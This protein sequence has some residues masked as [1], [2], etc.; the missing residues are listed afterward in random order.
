MDKTKQYLYGFDIGTQGSKGILTDETGEVLAYHYMKH[1]VY[2]PKPGWSE[3]DPE[4][5]WWHEFKMITRALLDKSG[6][7][8]KQIL[9]VGCSAI[10]PCMLPVDKEGRPLRNAILY[11]IDTRTT[12]EIRDMNEMIGVEKIISVGK[13]QLSSQAVGPK[14]LWFRR[15]ENELFQKTYKYLTAT[16]YLTFKLSGEYTMDFSNAI[17]YNPLFDADRRIWNEEMCSATGISTEQLPRLCPAHEVVGHITDEA[18][19]QTGMSTETLVIAGTGDFAAEL[20]STGAKEGETILVYG[21]TMLIMNLSRNCQYHPSLF[22]SAFPM[23]DLY[24]TGGSTATSA[25]ITKWFRDQFGEQ[26]RMAEAAG[27]TNAFAML[28]K[29][30]GGSPAGANGLITLPYFSGE[31]TPV[32]DENARGVFF[33]LTLGHTKA[34]VYRSILEGVAY[35]ARHNI[36]VMEE[37]GIRVNS[38]VSAGGGVKSREWIQIVSDVTGR[39]QRCLPQIG[40]SPAGDAYLAG[41]GCGLFNDMEQLRKE[42]VKDE[43]LVEPDRENTEKYEAFYRIYRQLYP[44]LKEQMREISM[45]QNEEVLK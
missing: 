12:K 22:L 19:E 36:D 35:S 14:I 10:S 5:V 43:I 29:L 25:S 42:W 4:K 9:A 13:V 17:G 41:Y 33:G 8:P 31:R 18:A 2:H 23:M 40:G 6:I 27:G 20:L 30:A 1:E 45:L 26:E 16:S 38:F 15:H 32:F 21:S 11:G 34:D 24:L 7:D 37:Q 44:A 28:S 39:P 3:H